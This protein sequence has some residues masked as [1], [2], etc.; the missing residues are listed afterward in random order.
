MKIQI[1]LGST[2][3]GR[4]S[5]KIAA[6]VM[7][8]VKNIPE[9]E[10]EL[11]DLRQYPL[12]FFD[13][14]ISPSQIKEPY[15]NPAVAKWTQKIAEGDA[16]L[17]VTPEYNHGYPAVLKNALD[18]VHKE[19]AG[20]K[21]GFVGFGTLGA[22]RAIEQLRQV[23]IELQM[24]PIKAAVHITKFWELE[25]FNQYNKNLGLVVEQLK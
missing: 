17:V 1:I 21:V 13:E 15:S 20:K 10:F 7:E 25:N 6:W 5:E 3:K 23:V 16:Y 22:A 11:L 24:I 9:I 2:R 18:Y 12:P 19:W 14:P 8:Q 4:F